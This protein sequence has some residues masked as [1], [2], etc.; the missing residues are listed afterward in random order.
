MT[1]FRQ[2]TPVWVTRSSISL[3]YVGQHDPREGLLQHP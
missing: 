2:V 1:G 3:P